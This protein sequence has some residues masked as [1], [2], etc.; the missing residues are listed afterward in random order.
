M[1]AVTRSVASIRYFRTSK[2]T[3]TQFDWS[4]SR[5]Y[6]C[7]PRNTE[8]ITRTERC[9][10]VCL[11]WTTTIAKKHND[12]VCLGYP[13][14]TNPVRRDPRFYQST[15]HADFNEKSRRSSS[16]PPMTGPPNSAGMINPGYVLTPW[17]GGGGHGA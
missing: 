11:S 8:L 6:T 10:Y 13:F 1:A 2:H 9:L 3:H 12:A 16:P 15:T 17:Y 7:A 5:L 14:S 4:P